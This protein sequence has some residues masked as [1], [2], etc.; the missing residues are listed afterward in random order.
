MST[1]ELMA[2]FGPDLEPILP[3][4]P[5]CIY[6]TDIATITSIN[7]YLSDLF[8][9]SA[10]LAAETLRGS[11]NFIS[12]IFNSGNVSNTTIESNFK[13]ISDSMTSY[14]QQNGA[15]INNHFAVGKVLQ[16]ET[17]VHVRWEWLIFPAVMFTLTLIFFVGMVIETTSKYA[18]LNGSHDFKS[19]ALPLV[20]SR[21][22]AQLSLRF[23]Q[24]TVGIN[25]M[26]EEAKQMRVKLMRNESGWKFIKDN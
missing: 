19:S 16:S 23:S 3:I 8:Q 10:G 11:S 9:G 17:C 20:F 4:N 24:G 12:A 18:L 25:E 22:E 26:T 1:S 21:V 2:D 5:A 14:I 6:Q 15:S 13:N 7:Y